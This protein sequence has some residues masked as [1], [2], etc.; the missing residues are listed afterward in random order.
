MD[1]LGE[2]KRALLKED[3]YMNL[4]AMMEKGKIKLLDDDEVKLSLRSVQYEYVS[5][6]GKPTKIRIFG[7]YTHIAEGLIRAA[8]L[9]NQKHLNA[10]IDYV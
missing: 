1:H 4:L 7:N 2:K 6:P 3:M 5:E 10:F 9:A 8:W